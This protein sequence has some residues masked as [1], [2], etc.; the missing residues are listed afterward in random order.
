MAAFIGIAVVGCSGTPEAAPTSTAVSAAASSPI[1]SA[2]RTQGLHAEWK[3]KFD[4]LAK[5]GDGAAPCAPERARSTACAGYL[6]PIVQAAL[7]LRTAINAR[8]DASAY[9]RTLAEI[10][11]MTTASGAYAKCPRAD[12]CYVQAIAISAGS[13]TMLQ[14]LQLDDPEMR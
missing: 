8:P 5:Q 4:T 6:T 2:A 3:P 14:R 12:D 10:D 11:K 1:S 9:A 13:I 7:D